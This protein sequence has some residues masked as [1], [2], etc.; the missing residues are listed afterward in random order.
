MATEPP[1]RQLQEWGGLGAVGGPQACGSEKGAGSPPQAEPRHEG[2][3][4]GNLP[5]NNHKQA[6]EPG[7]VWLIVRIKYYQ[8][9]TKESCPTDEQWAP[10]QDAVG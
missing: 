6:R 5:S 3:R 2:A 4:L 10:A 1:Q 9:L 7:R 8:A